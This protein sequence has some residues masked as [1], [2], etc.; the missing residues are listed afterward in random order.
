MND[1]DQTARHAV[2]ADPDG[3]LRWLF[4]KR[5]PKV[6]FSRWLDSQSAPRPGEPDRRC[7]TLAESVH[8][9]GTRPPIVSVIELFTSP[10]A[11]AL[12]R[13]LEYAG[14]FR[15]EVRH[16]PYQQDRYRFA[17]GLIFL[18]TAPEELAWQSH[19]DAEEDEDD[20]TVV[21]RPKVKVLSQESAVA[22]LESIEDNRLSRGILAWVSLAAGQSADVV[23]HWRRLVEPMPD[24]NWRRTLIDIVVVFAELTKSRD[25]WIAGLKGLNMNESITM[26]E[27]RNEGRNEGNV[28]ATRR[29]LIRLLESRNPAGLPQEVRDRIATEA[30]P[31]VLDR[32]FDLALTADLAA[33]RAAIRV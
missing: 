30:D 28:A 4:P 26:R 2:K 21:V 3:N 33:F 9:D 12:D 18:T 17:L 22:L 32:W 11:D 31:D 5:S 7:D 15:R 1:F 29:N 20:P 19:D 10:D 25:L 16:G 6:G 27:V 13:S 23:S 24:D 8:A 14:R